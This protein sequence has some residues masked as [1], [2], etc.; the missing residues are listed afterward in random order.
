[1][2][3]NMVS[4][5]QLIGGTRYTNLPLS[6]NIKFQDAMKKIEDLVYSLIETSKKN[7]KQDRTETLLDLLVKSVDDETLQALD[8]KT[9]RDNS[10][11]TYIC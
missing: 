4:L 9:L 6:E 5:K 7:M 11:Y 1:M 3:D 2:I 10:K 8:S